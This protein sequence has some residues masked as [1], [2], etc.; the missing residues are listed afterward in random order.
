MDVQELDEINEQQD[1]NYNLTSH[2]LRWFSVLMNVILTIHAGSFKSNSNTSV[3]GPVAE[4]DALFYSIVIVL[5]IQSFGYALVT[6]PRCRESVHRIYVDTA[7][8]QPYVFSSLSKYLIDH[9]KTAMCYWLLA[10]SS[11]FFASF[12]GI[13]LLLDRL[14]CSSESSYSL[15]KLSN[16]TVA[17]T[18]SEECSFQ[19]NVTADV[20]LSQ[21]ND[22]AVMSSVWAWNGVNVFEL[23]VYL[24]FAGVKDC[25]NRYISTTYALSNVLRTLVVGQV[26]PQVLFPLYVV[27]RWL[28]L[29]LCVSVKQCCSEALDCHQRSIDNSEVE[30]HHSVIV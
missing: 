11:Y 30:P 5:L 8:S 27:S 25:Y 2:P 18:A 17:Q 22:V 29:P 19:L 13:F 6:A 1:Q 4:N 23:I 21:L 12:N 9:P 20:M 7:V 10:I 15:P 3:Y 16:V 14:S 24:K 26:E 28:S